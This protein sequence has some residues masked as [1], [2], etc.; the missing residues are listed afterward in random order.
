[1]RLVPLA[2]MLGCAPASTGAALPDADR[3]DFADVVQ[4][5]LALHC[6]YSGCHGDPGRPYAVYARSA[7][8][9]DPDD[10][11]DD[12][13][14]TEAELDAN[15]DQTRALLFGIAEPLDSLLLSRPLARAAGGSGHG[16]GIQF[17][18]TTDPD[19]RALETW[20]Q[21]ALP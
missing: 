15:F 3:A 4:P 8:R 2:L 14:L 11:L 21:G 7:W 19:Y 20:V 5:R 1:M 10:V 16:G 9:A 12:P 17:T 13:P 6:A 18:D